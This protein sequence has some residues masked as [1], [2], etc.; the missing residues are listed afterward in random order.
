[1]AAHLLKELPPPKIHFPLG[2]G[3]CEEY[4][5]LECEDM[6]FVKSSPTFRAKILPPSSS[7]MN[8]FL[9]VPTGL[10]LLLSSLL[11]LHA[12]LVTFCVRFVIASI[13]KRR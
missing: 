13:P 8:E 6:K 4:F 1:V 5:L 10:M 11:F 12:E 9:F 2:C 3:F 7:F